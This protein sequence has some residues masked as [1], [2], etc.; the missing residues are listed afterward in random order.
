M[1]TCSQNFLNIFLKRFQF[2]NN[3]F[4]GFS[5]K[6]FKIYLNWFVNPNFQKKSFFYKSYRK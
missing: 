2:R 4:L 3:F 6:I 1:S 5:E